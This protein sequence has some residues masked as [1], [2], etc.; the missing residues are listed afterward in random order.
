MTFIKTNLV[1]ITCENTGIG[2]IYRPNR[3]SNIGLRVGN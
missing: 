1:V 3:L 2:C